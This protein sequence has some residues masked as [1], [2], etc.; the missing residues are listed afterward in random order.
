VGRLF[1]LEK[2]H[3]EDTYEFTSGV[4]FEKRIYSNQFNYQRIA[5]V[6]MG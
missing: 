3:K 1:E 5:S 6:W 4:L 2:Q